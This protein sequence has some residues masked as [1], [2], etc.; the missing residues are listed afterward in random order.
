MKKRVVLSSIFFSLI[1]LAFYFDNYIVKY[2]SLLRT[3]FLNDFFLGI[4]F[5]SSEIVVFFVLT[6]MF[7]YKE[8]K[9]KWILPLW[10]T[11]FLS[12]VVSFILKFSV[13]RLRPFQTGIVSVLPVLEKASHEVWN[14]S[15]PSFQAML[16]F[17]AI[18]I[19]SKEFPRFRWVWCLFAFLVAFSRMYFGVHFL[20]DVLVGGLVGYLIGIFVINLEK[21]YRFSEKFW[22]ILKE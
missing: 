5:V 3:D 4:T 20:S 15:F 21:K 19:L 11:L 7:L 18:P 22:N 6:S 13:K 8:H 12:V 2:V 16:V 17:C 9:R 1:L 14:F 10:F